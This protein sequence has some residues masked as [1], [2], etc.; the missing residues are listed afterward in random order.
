MNLVILE[1][2]EEYLLGLS[3]YLKKKFHNGLQVNSF[4]SLEKVKEYLEEKK[5]IDIFLSGILLSDIQEREFGA[6]QYI[7]LEDENIRENNGKL[8]LYKYQPRDALLK[9]FFSVC[10]LKGVTGLNLGDRKTDF[11]GIYSPV[12]RCGKTTMALTMAYMLSREKK[13]IYLSFETWPGFERYLG[14]YCG[15]NLSDLI[16]FIKQG[17]RNLTDY[18][19]ASVTRLKEFDVIAPVRNSPDIQLVEAKEFQ[20]L[21]QE[22]ADTNQYDVLILDFGDCFY[23]NLSL[24]KEL[25]RLCMPVLGDEI[26]LSKQMEFYKFLENSE[27]RDVKE[28]IVECKISRKRDEGTESIEALAEGSYGEQLKGYLE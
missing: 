9:N 4:C 15:M 21:L 19:L 25:D 24:M 3:C 23:R 8:M 17:K 16:Y 18:I 12:G 13:V 1:E 7:Y 2:E 22:I 14:D 6:K 5:E 11:I 28:K 27:Y 26:S 20:V 10:D